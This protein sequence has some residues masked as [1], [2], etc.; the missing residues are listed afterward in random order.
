M[1]VS[2]V[3]VDAREEMTRRMHDSLRQGKCSLRQRDASSMHAEIEIEVEVNRGRRDSFLQS[4][5]SN[6]T[7][8]DDGKA[9][10]R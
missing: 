3:G 10:L 9:R 5:Q 4:I 2:V 8:N 7:V 6:L 1:N